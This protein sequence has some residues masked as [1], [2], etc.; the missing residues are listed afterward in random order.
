MD[1]KEVQKVVSDLEYAIGKLEAFENLS[2][3]TDSLSSIEKNIKSLKKVSAKTIIVNGVIG[4]AI[5]AAIGFG[6]VKI[7]E[8]QNFQI[9]ALQKFNLTL[10]EDGDGIALYVPKSALSSQNKDFVIF[11]YNKK[12]EKKDKK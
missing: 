11:H 4:L 12:Q 3:L 7:Y 10:A 6:S 1:I 5:G 9:K 8:S 2:D